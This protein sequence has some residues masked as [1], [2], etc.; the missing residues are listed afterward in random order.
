MEF[1]EV[2]ADI[3]SHPFFQPALRVV[4]VQLALVV[5]DDVETATVRAFEDEPFGEAF[6]I[7][8]LGAAVHAQQVDQDVAEAVLLDIRTDG[9]FVRASRFRG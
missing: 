2:S 6:N 3:G 1:A 7:D 4:N 9:V 8:L 5:T